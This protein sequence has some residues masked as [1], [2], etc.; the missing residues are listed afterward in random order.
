[1]NK[2]TYYKNIAE[3]TIAHGA[4]TNS[5][6]T[7]CFVEGVYPSHVET[8]FKCYLTDMNKQKY[9]DYICGLGTNLFGY[10][11]LE[12]NEAVKSALNTGGSAFSLSTNLEV[13]LSQKFIDTFP[14]IGRVRF[15][16]TGS[17]GCSAAIKIARAFTG[18]D[19]IISDGYHGWHDSFIG[20]TPPAHGVIADPYISNTEE[21][22]ASKDIA[23]YIIEP[24]ITDNSKE[25]IARLSQLREFCTRNGILLIF[26]E[27]IT[28]YRYKDFSV[29]HHHNIYPDIWIGGKAIAGGLPLSVVGG[30]S[31]V[32]DT[33]YFISSTWA[34][35][36]LAIAAAIK[37]IELIHG[38]FHPNELWLY[39]E[40]F[41]E[42]FNKISEYVKIKGYPTRGTFVYPNDKFK[43]LFMQEMCLAGVLFG[44]SWFYNKW[45]HKEKDNV[46]SITKAV[47]KKILKGHVLLK[48]GL[49]KNPY[50]ER[51]RNAR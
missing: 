3:T 44:P 14:F 15:L 42:E 22:I 1:M 24:V 8:G 26:D 30:K 29:A 23:A 4:L 7:S 49:P 51:I 12:I 18:R 11:N 36:R 40:E 38:D 16:K 43:A 5:K 48:G 46:I 21:N 17:E 35:D 2:N 19:W 9:I 31:Y 45:L 39:G 47:I 33:E 27:T 20:L 28:A 10:G 37:S 32:M 25:R 34:G 41:L 6:R 50:A 13:E